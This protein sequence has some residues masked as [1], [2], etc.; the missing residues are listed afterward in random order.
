MLDDDDEEDDMVGKGINASEEE[1][2]GKG[3]P[4]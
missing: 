3:L 4:T 1:G 2:G